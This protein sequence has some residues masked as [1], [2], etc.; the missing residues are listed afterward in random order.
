MCTLK[1]AQSFEFVYYWFIGRSS[2]G[3]SP[4]RAFIAKSWSSY[5]LSYQGP[6]VSVRHHNCCRLSWCRLSRLF[7]LVPGYT[8]VRFHGCAYRRVLRLRSRFPAYVQAPNF[9][10]SL[11]S[12]ECLVTRNTHAQKPKFAASPWNTLTVSTKFPASIADSVLTVS[13]TMK[14]GLGGKGGC[15]GSVR[16]VK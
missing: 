4:T 6:S 16:W 1:L 12:V 9:C 10:T 7:W 13:R 8:R 15:I 14:L 5:V 11:V 3:R 2:R